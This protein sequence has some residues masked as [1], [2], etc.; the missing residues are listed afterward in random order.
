[1]RS[2]VQGFA[3]FGKHVQVYTTTV[4]GPIAPFPRRDV[5]SHSRLRLKKWPIEEEY[6]KE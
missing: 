6:V 5:H 4:R 2:R 3:I 1:M